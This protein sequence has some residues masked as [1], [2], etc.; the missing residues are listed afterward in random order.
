LPKLTFSEVKK[1][2]TLDF[3]SFKSDLTAKYQSEKTLFILI[4]HS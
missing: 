1:I 4:N 2:R 3:H